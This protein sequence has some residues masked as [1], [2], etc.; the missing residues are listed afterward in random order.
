MPETA[1]RLLPYATVRIDILTPGGGATT[2]QE[3]DI[4]EA[5]EQ[6]EKVVW[7]VLRDAGWEQFEVRCD[8]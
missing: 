1:T 6:A 4:A 8:Y 3:D 2:A 5:Y 7:K